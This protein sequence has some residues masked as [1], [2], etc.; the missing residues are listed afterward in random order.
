[1]RGRC[2]PWRRI[3]LKTEYRSVTQIWFPWCFA[4]CASDYV[5][6]MKPTW[7]TI[8]SLYWESRASTCFE[9]YL[10]IL[11]RRHKRNLVYCVRIHAVSV[12]CGKVSVKLSNVVCTAPPENEQVM[13]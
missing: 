12:G 2:C 4:D 7:C 6:I 10:L 13:L 9:H 3:F 11:R 1:M 8:R 5:S